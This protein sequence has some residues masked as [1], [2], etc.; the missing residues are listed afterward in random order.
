VREPDFFEWLKAAIDPNSLGQTGGSTDRIFTKTKS[1]IPGTGTIVAWEACKDLHL[2]RIGANIIDQSDADSI[3]TCIRSQ[4]TDASGNSLTDP[5]PFDSYGQENIPYLNEVITSVYRSGSSANLNGYM[6]FELWNPNRNAATSANPPLDYQGNPITKFNVCAT[7]GTVLMMP[8]VY[9][10]S[11][12]AY[13]YIDDITGKSATES[14]NSAWGAY[15]KIAQYSQGFL[16]FI[17]PVD[18][19][20]TSVAFTLATPGAGTFFSEP[21]LVNGSQP[22]GQDLTNP[23]TAKFSTVSRPLV[24]GAPPSDGVNAM[25]VCSVNAPHPA[26]PA[27]TKLSDLYT[28]ISGTNTP[29]STGTSGAKYYNA[30][31]FYSDGTTRNGVISKPVTL[32]VEL[33]DAGGITH[34]CQTYNN[35]AMGT[36][37]TAF[38]RHGSVRSDDSNTYVESNWSK[39]S[40]TSAS[41]TISACFYN[42]NEWQIR[43]GYPNTDPRTERFG[44]TDN[45][46]ATPGAS[47]RTD[48]TAYAFALFSP[49]DIGDASSVGTSFANG[50]NVPSNEG[51]ASGWG[52]C[53]NAPTVSVPADLAVNSGITGGTSSTHCY[54]DFDGKVRPADARYACAGAVNGS[55]HPAL[56]VASFPN[57]ALSRPV[58]LNRPFRNVAELGCVFR[59]VPWKSLDLFSPVSPDRRL[60]DVFCIE[61]RA[62]TTGKINPNLATQETLRALLRNTGDV[63][64]TNGTPLISGTV[65]STASNPVADMLATLNPITSSSNYILSNA[66]IAQRLADPSSPASPASLANT[67]G[68]LS[69]KT[70]AESFARALSSMTDTRSWQ[71]M[72]DVVAQ[73]GKIP[74]Q[75][76]ALGN[77]GGFVVDGQRR[78][79]VYLTLDRLTGEILDKH[80]EPVYE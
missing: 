59:D 36:R 4:F 73:S 6:Q 9:V 34:T 37:L 49:V 5:S 50:N 1:G 80:I 14:T 67:G 11:V 8:F 48:T 28:S 68:Y 32:V 46:F 38:D 2:I 77:L 27:G 29:V 66:N 42:W 52:L 25:L 78:F 21:Y 13:K 16:P 22:N 72:L 69:Y 43:K 35:L 71:L 76:A 26:I 24:L 56:P 75:D 79:F 15:Q 65:P 60:L 40:T 39:S 53:G 74:P 63:P 54:A 64:T 12:T 55:A 61:D 33:T 31:R 23:V 57:A 3:P 20:K 10:S 62:T 58:V 70:R 45:I 30:A 17:P 41:G 51:P 44:F 18:I 47:I 19:T 7:S